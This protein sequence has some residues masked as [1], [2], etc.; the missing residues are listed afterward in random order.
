MDNQNNKD[1]SNPS[2]MSR[3]A[4]YLAK[5]SEE[6]KSAKKENDRLRLQNKRA[7]RSEEE[8]RKELD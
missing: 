2:G 4:N 1:D 8:N 7:N 6:K 5:Q 3:Y